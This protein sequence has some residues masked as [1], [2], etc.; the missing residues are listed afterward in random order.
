MQVWYKLLILK[1]NPFL[2]HF[3]YE[4]SIGRILLETGEVGLRTLI[5]VDGEEETLH[6]RVFAGMSSL[7]K[8]STPEKLKH[9]QTGNYVDAK[10]Q[11]GMSSLIIQQLE[12]YFSGSRKEFDIPLDLQGTDFQKKVWTELLKIPYGTTISY[13]ELAIRLGDLKCIRAAGTANG[14]NP[15]SIIVPCHRVIGSDASLVG[16]GGGLWRKKWLLEHEGL[17]IVKGQLTI[18]D[19]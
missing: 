1:A 14:A 11:T 12:E 4:S 2:M 5:F 19:N 18:F 3:F 6:K 9:Y 15:V 7:I 17:S 10:G 13:K 8:V 16:Y